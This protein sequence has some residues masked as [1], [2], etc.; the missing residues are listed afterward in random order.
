[1]QIIDDNQQECATGITGHLAIKIKR[2]K[3]V[4]LFSGISKRCKKHLKN[5]ENHFTKS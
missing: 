5:I 3:P 2:K 4:G 1:L